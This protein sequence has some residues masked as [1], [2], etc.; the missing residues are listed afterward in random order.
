MPRSEICLDDST[1]S[2]LNLQIFQSEAAD[3]DGF[4]RPLQVLRSL[5]NVMVAFEPGNLNFSCTRVTLA[6]RLSLRLRRF[7]A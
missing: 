2:A 1:V 6:L 3:C 4:G 5:A 7:S